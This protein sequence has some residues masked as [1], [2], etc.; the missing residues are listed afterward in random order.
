MTRLPVDSRLLEVLA[1]HGTARVIRLVDTPGLVALQQDH[2][3]VVMD[4]EAWLWLVHAGAPA[5][6]DVLPAEVER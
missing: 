5:A 6:L 4:R 3:T 1:E 2:E